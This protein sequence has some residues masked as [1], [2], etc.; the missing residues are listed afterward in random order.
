MT[1][2]NKQV[3]QYRK[4]DFIPIVGVRKHMNRCFEEME[5]HPILNWS[6]KYNAQCFIRDAGLI[7]YNVAIFLPPLLI[8][9]EKL[10]GD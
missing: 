4:E 2:E 3:Y 7:F 10:A 8:G 1:T 5:K 6:E 9:L